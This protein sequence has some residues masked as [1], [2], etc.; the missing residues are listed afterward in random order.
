MRS[1]KEL[2]QIVYKVHLKD[3]ELSK[4]CNKEM[5]G[6]CE[7]LTILKAFKFNK[8]ELNIMNNYFNEKFIKMDKTD[9]NYYF[10]NN[11]KSKDR[12]EFLEQCLKELEE[13]EQ[14]F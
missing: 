5:F 1:L 11:P 12:T 13:E 9:L 2:V 10:S 8:S 7:I 6:I 14:K 4:I 3:I